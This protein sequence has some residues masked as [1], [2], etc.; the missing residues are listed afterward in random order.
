MNHDGGFRRF[1]GGSHH[2]I[3]AELRGG[4]L[5][6][7]GR[8]SL[9]SEH[10]V[11]VQPV[12]KFFGN[13]HSFDIRPALRMLSTAWPVP[14]ETNASKNAPGD[15]AAAGG[16]EIDVLL[17]AAVEIAAAAGFEQIEID[18]PGRCIFQI[19]GGVVIAVDYFDAGLALH[20]DQIFDEALD[21]LGVVFG[22]KL[23]S[24]GPARECRRIRRIIS[25]ALR[26]WARGV[27]CR[28]RPD[29]RE[30]GICQTPASSR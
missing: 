18:R 14:F 12:I 30:R 21:K 25:I 24:D 1:E 3:V 23:G 7:L 13:E 20:V 2:Q 4:P 28:N 9:A 11:R 15:A 22:A 29:R 16:A 6:D 8:G 5:D 19:S 26:S 17:V 27:P 10:L